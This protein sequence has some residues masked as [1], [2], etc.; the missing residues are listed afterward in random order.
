MQISYRFRQIFW[1]IYFVLTIGLVG[2]LFGY[3]FTF[4]LY[5]AAFL[6]SPWKGPSD[7]IRHGGEFFQCASIRFLLRLQPWLRAETNLPELRGFYDNFGTRRVLFVGNHRS[8]LDTF[9]LISYVPGLRGLAKSSLFYNIFFAPFMWVAGFIPV[10]KGS[11]ESFMEGLKM[12]RT[13]LLER[14]RPV[15][16]FPENTR[17]KKGASSLEKF[18]AAVFSMAIDAEALIVPLA[19]VGTDDV[20]GK[21]EFWLS[22]GHPIRIKMLP[23]VRASDYTDAQALRDR[24]REALKVELP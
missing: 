10:K 15:L 5:F 14:E 4:A 1:S 13:K 11:P 12:L 16:I 21:G 6:L 20:L 8:N 7:R 23:P 3:V 2:S 18:S 17:C 9:L 19:I 22:P 24:V